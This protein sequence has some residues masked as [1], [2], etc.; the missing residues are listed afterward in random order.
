MSSTTRLGVIV[1]PTRYLD[2]TTERV[3]HTLDLLDLDAK[4]AEPDRIALEFFA[5]GFALDPRQPSRAALFEK[6]GPGACYVDL[7][8]LAVLAPIAPLSGHAF[9]G[10]GAY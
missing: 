8:A 4:Q 6:R 10:H 5:H 9:Y 3:A 7:G 2:P 1:G